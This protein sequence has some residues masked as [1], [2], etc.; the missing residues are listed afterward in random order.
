MTTFVPSA[1][2]SDMK[3]ATFVP[4][5]DESDIEVTMEEFLECLKK[6]K[7][8]PFPDESK[9]F[10]ISRTDVLY[11]ADSINDIIPVALV[12][13]NIKNVSRENL[14]DMKED[15]ETEMD[16]LTEKEKKIKECIKNIK[17]MLKSKAKGAK[18]KG[19]ELKEL[20]SRPFNIYVK[21]INFPW[22]KTTFELTVS[23][24]TTVA[25]LTG[26]IA[27][28]LIGELPELKRLKL[29]E[30]DKK[31]LIASL[32]LVSDAVPF[33][34]AYGRKTI[35]ELGV[36][37]NLTV[38]VMTRIKGGGKRAKGT[39]T[40]E[41]DGMML[42]R[43]LH[44]LLDEKIL[45]LENIQSPAPVVKETVEQVKFI[46]KT[47]QEDP[48]SVVT[49]LLEHVNDEKLMMMMIL[50]ILNTSTRVMDRCRFVKENCL[51]DLHFKTEDLVKQQ[52]LTS[53]T[54]VLGIRLAVSCQFS[55]SNG[56]IAWTALIDQMTKIVK[57]RA[58]SSNAKAKDD[59]NCSLM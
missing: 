46:M 3:V 27:D 12:K 31:N 54:L 42:T 6:D 25:T 11:S 17:D 50:G 44:K 10:D 38:S 4:S 5:S 7:G 22:M 37:P 1:D 56:S 47:A 57:D 40:E 29:Q 33:E 20:K 48:K 52:G 34:S 30:K 58:G 36:T 26:S 16:E 8:D 13:G 35:G 19:D 53:E 14:L 32:R 55:E 18:L 28:R 39:K 41:S 45:R 15:L 49:T 59:T 43:D 9:D 24:G 21:P 2:E 51:E 23:L